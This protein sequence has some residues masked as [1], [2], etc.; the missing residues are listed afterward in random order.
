MALSLFR[1][2]RGRLL[3]LMI[4]IVL[5][6]ACLTAAA[7]VATYRTVFEAIQ[8]SQTRAA[9]DFAVRARVWYRGALR[10]LVA[11]SSAIRAVSPAADSCDRIA[12]KAIAAVPGYE[13]FLLR[14]AG[15]PD[16]VG[17]LDG[18]IP[19][20]KLAAV[21]G[22]LATR[23]PVKLWGGTE[24]TKARYDQVTIAG[25]SYL[26]IHSEFDEGDALLL[27]KPD[28]LDDVFDL[29][30]NDKGMMAAL[31]RRGGQVVVA[32]GGAQSEASW[33]PKIESVPDRT[34]HWTAPSRGGPSR[35][36]AA[37]MVSEPD[38]Y[39][40]VSFDG[41][42]ERA[43]TTQFYI[44]L[45]APL[46]TLTLLGLV[47]MKAIDQ[48]CVRWLRGIEATAR[49]RSSSAGARVPLSD[50][51]PC[52]IRSVAEAFNAMVDEQEVR[53]NKLRLALD[54]NRFLVR[55][56]HHR[57]KNSLQVVQS[58]I[59]L[60][61][62]DHKGEA[63][64]ALSDAEC[65][66]HVLSAA[67]RFTLADG[68]MQPVRID[69]FLDDVVAMVSSLI[70]ARGQRLESRI[71]TQATLPI[72][73]IIP[74]GLLIVDVASRALRAAPGL[75]LELAVTNAGE[76]IIDIAIT[77]DRDTA[78]IAPPRLFAGLL[79][80]IEAVEISPPQGR[81]LGVWRL[82][83][84]A[85]RKVEEAQPGAPAGVISTPTLSPRN[86]PVGPT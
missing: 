17:G 54:D 50:Q 74:L 16:C 68:E 79:M 3:A 34:A 46:L 65:R 62:R 5:P 59:G 73:R 14:V 37:R 15:R 69:L 33:L 60:A 72:D 51:M 21:A 75:G 31:L 77:T 42:A 13:A 66:V 67:Y 26:A 28:P 23:P 24:F 30:G 58:Y 9:D 43:A 18:S 84:G 85:L 47:Y 82:G 76:G 45:L 12:E 55:E 44:L 63:R 36:Y 48:H 27:S 2:V 29:G 22:Q 25:R 35:N 80:Q 6:I 38:L 70:V 52:D 71:G 64:M 61:K 49:A 11:S 78:Q 8:T 81:S 19:R 39:V 86:A 83:H 4:A 56:L 7:A 40:L 57:V 32:R 1:T 53:Q 20:S 10:S 41:S